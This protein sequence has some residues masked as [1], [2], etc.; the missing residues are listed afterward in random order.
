[1]NTTNL[2]NSSTVRSIMKDLRNGEHYRN[3]FLEISFCNQDKDT[4]L[5]ESF[6]NGERSRKELGATATRRII[7]DNINTR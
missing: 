5:V 6:Y 3:G 1:M 2:D 7:S 4:F